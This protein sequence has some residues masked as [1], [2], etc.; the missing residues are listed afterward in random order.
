MSVYTKFCCCFLLTTL[1][2][3]VINCTALFDS[4]IVNGSAAFPGEF[5]FMVSLRRAS[6]GR[7]SCGASLLNRVWVLT[8]AHCVAK[9][10]PIQ[11]N[12]Q[13]GSIELDKNSTE[14]ANVSKIYVHEGYEPANQYIHDIALLRLEKPVNV[15]EDFVGVRLP[16]LN[17]ITDNKT[18][19]TLIGWGLNA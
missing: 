3:S 13:Y 11:I 4:K 15:K 9:A 14:L 7:H 12:V 1:F 16:E 18:P 5:P 19:V 17:A 8:A 10:K 2:C 6:S